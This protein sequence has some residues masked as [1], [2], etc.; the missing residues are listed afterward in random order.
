MMSMFSILGHI[1]ITL[2]IYVYTYEAYCLT[3]IGL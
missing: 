3:L 1:D 2:V